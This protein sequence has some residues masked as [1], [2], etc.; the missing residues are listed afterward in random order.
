MKRAAALAVGAFA[1]VGVSP[2]A[3]AHPTGNTNTNVN[4]NVNAN[5]NANVNNNVVN[6]GGSRINVKGGP[7]R[8]VVVVP[9]ARPFPVAGQ[10]QTQSQFQQQSQ[11]QS[12]FQS[13]SLRFR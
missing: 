10:R 8:V 7:P 3:L 11:S 6:V 4:A 9:P 5:T 12:Q 13:F 2:Q 1:L